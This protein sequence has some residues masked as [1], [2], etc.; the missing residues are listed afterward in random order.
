MNVVVEIVSSRYVMDSGGSVRTVR[1]EDGQ[2]YVAWGIAIGDDV[3]AYDYT[4]YGPYS[5]AEE[6]ITIMEGR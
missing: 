4:V 6:A 2:Y 3:H 1:C 5:T